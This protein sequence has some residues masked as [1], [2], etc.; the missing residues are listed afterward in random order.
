MDSF[1]CLIVEREPGLTNTMLGVA[2]LAGSIRVTVW[3][4]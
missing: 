1:G 3:D 2:N 4:G